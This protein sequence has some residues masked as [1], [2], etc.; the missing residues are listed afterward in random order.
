[1]KELITEIASRSVETQTD[2]SGI[3]LEFINAG[4][5]CYIV[6]PPAYRCVQPPQPAFYY[7]QFFMAP[8]PPPTTHTLPST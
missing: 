8:H 6:Q 3:N 4:P 5:N 1:M 2:I 7:N